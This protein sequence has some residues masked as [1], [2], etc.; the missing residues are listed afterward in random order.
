M[1]PQTT[2]RPY[3]FTAQ[4][5]LEPTKESKVISLVKRNGGIVSR[6]EVA[7]CLGLSDGAH[8]DT[9]MDRAGIGQIGTYKTGNGRPTKLYGFKTA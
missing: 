4:I 5:T 8:L 1:S 2:W 7:K 3:P 9:I 6:K